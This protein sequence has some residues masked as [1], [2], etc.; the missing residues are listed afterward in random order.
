MGR[1]RIGLISAVLAACL[2][3]QP[4]FAQPVQNEF[5]YL[6][7]PSV[8]KLLSPGLV[9]AKDW[10]QL[11][12]AGLSRVTEVFVDSNA[13]EFEL[14]SDSEISIRIPEGVSPGDAVLR[15]SGD[16]GLLSYQN[17]FEV[18]PSAKAVE[19]KITIGTF[20]GF[21]A[22]YTKN[23]KGKELRIVIGDR[24]RVIPSLGA[25]YTQNLTKVGVGKTVS[26]SVFVD[27]ILS[28]SNQL[29]IQ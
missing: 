9:E 5:E 12:G 26:I 3:S 11:S 15:I 18:L 28:K 17:L 25:N 29:E 14:S 1:R 22:V 13:A 10:I 6:S 24:T 21:A 4:A 16:F 7:K 23:F 2:F 27:G 8:I 20:Q 19:P